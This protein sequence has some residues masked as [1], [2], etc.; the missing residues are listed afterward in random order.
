MSVEVWWTMFSLKKS[1]SF[2]APLRRPSCLVSTAVYK[3]LA[4]NVFHSC[5]AHIYG[6]LRA[7]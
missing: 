7:D 4:S 2:A 5:K 1:L 3:R 6:L